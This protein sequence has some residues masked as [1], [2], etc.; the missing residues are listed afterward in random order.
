MFNVQK[1]VFSFKLKN[2]AGLP[3]RC[4]STKPRPPRNPRDNA[5]F[6][7]LSKKSEFKNKIGQFVKLPILPN[8][9][10]E[11][12]KEISKGFLLTKQHAE[13]LERI[14][15]EVEAGGKQDKGLVL[16]GP[17]GIGKSFFTYLVA[18]YAWVNKYPLIYI[19]RISISVTLLFIKQVDVE[20]FLCIQIQARCGAW[21][22]TYNQSDTDFNLPADYWLKQ[23]VLLNND[24]LINK[25]FERINSVLN[26]NSLTSRQK[27][28][29][30]M[31]ELGDVNTNV[32]SCC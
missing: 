20:I 13:I 19:V 11:F 10:K 23:F 1:V 28:I 3:H 26:D 14:I 5:K 30:I 25:K 15:K 24:I 6:K 32:V 2:L 7:W 16:Y 22:G 21:T 31:L 8:V 9:P 27:Q 29:T 12:E 17:Q 18:S 4:Y